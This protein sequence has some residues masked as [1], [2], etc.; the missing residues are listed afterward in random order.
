MP[1]REEIDS[2]MASLHLLPQVVSAA[3]LGMTVDQPGWLEARKL[4][5]K[6]YAAATSALFY[7]DTSIGLRDAVLA[8]QREHPARAG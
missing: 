5:G 2:L 3:L 7:Q 6:A 4:A 1:S 8:D